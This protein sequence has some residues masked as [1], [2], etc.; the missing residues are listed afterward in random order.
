VAQVDCGCS[1]EVALHL[2]GL[3]LLVS[4]ELVVAFVLVIGE[5]EQRVEGSYALLISL[6]PEE[7]SA[8]FNFS[9]IILNQSLTL[10]EEVKLLLKR[11]L[12]STTDSINLA[13]H[14]LGLFY[15][16]LWVHV[17]GLRSLDKA[18][19]NFHAHL[20]E[21][22]LLTD[23]LSVTE[24]D[25]ILGLDVPACH[26][27]CLGKRL[28]CLPVILV[29]GLLIDFVLIDL[30]EVAGA[31]LV[32]DEVAHELADPAILVRWN[33]ELVEQVVDGADRV[34]GGLK[35]VGHAFQSLGVLVVHIV[36]IH[37]KEHAQ[38]SL[39]K[40]LLQLVV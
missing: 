30:E 21:L 10:L 36:E 33:E 3:L 12:F 9:L 17:V 7:V 19:L 32:F 14:S 8:Q 4:D 6:Q 20:S 23:Q 31:I 27:D 35:G 39:G 34:G 18:L 11:G 16:F 29:N 15:F 1:C 2:L 37:A 28:R 40:A 38:F 22:V 5:A 25:F 26:L 24:F 13:F